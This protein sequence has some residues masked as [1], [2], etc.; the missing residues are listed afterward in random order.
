MEG[1]INL[2]VDTETGGILPYKDPEKNK[3]YMRKYSRERMRKERAANPELHRQRGISFRN[4]NPLSRILT[5]TKQ[6]AKLKGLEHNITVEDLQQVL[7]CPYTKIEIDW[8]V[9]GKHMRN[10][11]VDR[12]DNSKGYIKG[13]VEVI[14]NLANSMKNQAT[15]E[16]LQNFA[17]EVLKRY[18][19]D[20]SSS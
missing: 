5:S 2:V 10:P 8:S 3:E 20:K 4:R 15:V 1:K 12:I 19:I 13:N 9:S 17:L 14:S 18:P 11:S 7:I 6:T 16:Q